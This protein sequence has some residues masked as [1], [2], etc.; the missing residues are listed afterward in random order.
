MRNEMRFRMVEKIDPGRYKLL[1][2]AA[3]EVVTRRAAIYRQL[4][5]LT[6][7]AGTDTAAADSQPTAGQEERV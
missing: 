4:A 7:P 1:A 2:T 5:Q 6:V 3:Q